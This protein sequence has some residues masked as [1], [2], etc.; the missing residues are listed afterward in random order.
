MPPH[1][2]E[3]RGRASWIPSRSRRDVASVWRQIF[4]HHLLARIYCR[5]DPL[6]SNRTPHALSCSRP[7]TPLSAD[8]P[9]RMYRLEPPSMLMANRAPGI[10]E[11]NETAGTNRFLLSESD[12]SREC[13][14]NPS[15]LRCNLRDK[16]QPLLTRPRPNHQ[17]ITSIGLLNIRES[18]PSLR[19]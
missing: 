8:H 15:V 14:G 1:N 19:S 13:S 4:E 16:C 17:I 10:P 2:F 3:I 5:L 7:S 12:Q 6:C 11:S 18:Q 9:R